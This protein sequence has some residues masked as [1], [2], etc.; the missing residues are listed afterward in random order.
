MKVILLRDVAKLGKRFSV[1]EVPNGYALNQLIPKG[2]VEAATAENLKR[3][4]ARM[5][6]QQSTKVSNESDFGAALAALQA[7]PVTL[8][9][10]ANAQ[11]HLFKGVKATDI[12][13][14]AATAGH[15][16]PVDSIILIEPIKSLGAHQVSARL[17]TA[18]GEFTLT[19]VSK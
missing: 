12:A 6:K 1:V 11:G 2:M 9:V 18:R 13:A 19:L 8:A 4:G 16:I 5:E 17:G 7:T 14:A 10:Q 3:V 15:A